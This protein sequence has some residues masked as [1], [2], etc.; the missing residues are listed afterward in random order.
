MSWAEMVAWVLG[1]GTLG[2]VG[3][4]WVL[5]TYSD[6]AKERRGER[7]ESIAILH[8]TTQVNQLA[9]RVG[10]LEAQ[11]QRRDDEVAE[12]NRALD[13][14]RKVRRAAE[15]ALDV[16]QRARRALEQRVAELER[17]SG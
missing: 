5:E 6:R 17:K 16:E 13:E 15:D 2:G 4:K 8:L 14:E 11:I 7:A 3:L 9:H 10:E 12:L 1:G